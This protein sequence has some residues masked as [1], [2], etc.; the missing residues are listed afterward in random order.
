MSLPYLKMQGAG[1][2]IVV[3]D[4]RVGGRE[5]ERGCVVIGGRRLAQ[6]ERDAVEEDRD[7]LVRAGALVEEP[8][9]IERVLAGS[10]KLT[11]VVQPKVSNAYDRVAVTA[12]LA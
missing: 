4:Q 11:A 5:R 12:S 10:M 7:A 2:Q 1:N 9:E 3:V 8:A 6:R